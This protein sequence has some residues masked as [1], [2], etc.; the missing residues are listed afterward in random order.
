MTFTEL[1]A[2]GYLQKTKM[3]FTGA[4]C[5]QSDQWSVVEKTQYRNKPVFIKYMFAMLCLLISI[6]R[7]GAYYTYTAPKEVKIY[8]YLN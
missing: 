8:T 4:D 3:R 1:K 2:L 7:V 5:D 6:A